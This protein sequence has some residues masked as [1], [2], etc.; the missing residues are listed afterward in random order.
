MITSFFSKSKPINFIV[1]FF[2]IG[3]ACL[4]SFFKLQNHPIG[5]NSILKFMVFFIGSY[6]SMLIV[7]F[8]STKNG[9]TQTTNF[10]IVLYGLFLL[11]VPQATDNLA[12]ILANIFL[13]FSARRL[14][15]LR[16]QKNVKK[17]L[18]D[19]AFWI[20]VAMLCYPWSALFILLVPVS[21]FLYTENKLRHWLIP[22]TAIISVL[23]ISYSISFFMDF[24]LLI[25]LFKKSRISFD[26]SAY[27]TIQFLIALTVLLSFG[28]WSF[29]FYIKNIKSK[30][31]ALRPAFYIIIWASILSFLILILAPQKTG[32]EFL[33]MF[34]PLAIIISNYL[35][36]VKEKWFK[37]VFFSVLLIVP[38]VLLFL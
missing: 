24:D 37:E 13:L 23:L 35:E 18:F 3:I 26:F 15:S 21:I 8:V 36:I 12:V 19:A 10:E 32:A 29:L 34:A 9:L 1:G 30:K 20:T 6:F 7:N 22:I 28:L 38:F 5:I 4:F 31:K 2:I 16:S 27:N 14:I 17:K 25:H 11:M 33:F